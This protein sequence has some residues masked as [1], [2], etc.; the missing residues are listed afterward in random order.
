MSDPEIF[1]VGG[2]VQASGGLYLTR[3]VDSELLALCRARAYTYI[4]T[5]RQL[6]KSSLMVNT[7][8]RLSAEGVLPVLI[9]LT[10]CGLLAT[11]EEW[12]FG[13]VTLIAGALGESQDL[14]TWWT[15]LSALSVTQRLLRFFEDI[16]LARTEAPIV[17]FVDEIDCTLSLDFTDD[18]FVAIRL[19]HNARS[20][21]PALR[22]LTFV[23]IGVASPAE[24]Y[25]DPRRTPFNIGRRVELTDFTLSEVAPLAAGLPGSE[26]DR[27]QTLKWALAW[28]GGHP[29][30]TQRLCAAIAAEGQPPAS[31]DRMDALVATLFKGDLGRT[32]SNL[33]FVRD[34]LVRPSTIAPAVL[35]AYREVL[36]SRRPVPDDTQSMPKTRLKL[37]GIVTT[38]D[39]HLRVRNRLYAEVFDLDWIDRNWPR[40]WWS[41]IPYQVRVALILILIM[42][43]AL[44]ATA[45]YAVRQQRQAVAAAQL[46]DQ[47]TRLATG[48]LLTAES[49]ILSN[50]RQP[51]LSALLAIEVL[52]HGQPSDAGTSIVAENVL[53][54][55][56]EALKASI[57]YGH[58]G[59][60]WDVI[61]TPDGKWLVSSDTDGTALLW[62]VRRDA[63]QAPSI[64]LAGHDGRIWA[65]DISGD[66]RWLATA[67]AD[68]TA[69]LWDLEQPDPV[70]NPVILRAHDAPTLSLTFSPDGTLLATGGADG[71]LGLWRSQDS[72]WVRTLDTPWSLGAWVWDL[73]F[74]DDG[75]WLAA[76]DRTKT[77]RVWDLS[78][79]PTAAGLALH[80]HS[81]AI[82]DIEFI[83]GSSTLI[84]AGLDEL[85][86][87][88]DLTL[89]DPTGYP[90]ALGRHKDGIIAIAVNPD[91]RWL[92]T[93][94]LDQKVRLW[95][96]QSQTG[97]PAA[98]LRG[99]TELIFDEAFS[100]DGRY[101]ATS[102]SDHT[103]WLWNVAMEDPA[104]DAMTLLGHDDA[105][106][107][108][109]FSPQ[110]R[111]L[112]SAGWDG[113]VQL[114]DLSTPLSASSPFLLQ[115]HSSVVGRLAFSQHDQLL[116]TADANTGTLLWD[117]EID[118]F[119]PDPVAQLPVRAASASNRW[120]LVADEAGYA[121]I[122]G[123]EHVPRNAPLLLPPVTDW[124]DALALSD[125]G[126]WVVTAS[127]EPE[128]P[129]WESVILYPSVSQGRA[130][131]PPRLWDVSLLLADSALPAS[132]NTN[133]AREL[134]GLE[135]GVLLAHF[136]PDGHWLLTE[137]PDFVGALWPLPTSPDR[138]APRLLP[139][140]S[141]R[142]RA[143]FSADGRWLATA[144]ED[145]TVR[146]WD[147][148][149]TDLESTVRI[150]KNP[151]RTWD[152]A[153]SPDNRW[154]VTG[155]SDFAARLR[156]MS[157]L[158]TLEKPIVLRGHG[159]AVFSVAFS[160]DGRWLVTGSLDQTIRVWDLAT[161]GPAA[162]TPRVLV[163]HDDWV[164]ALAFSH[165]SRRLLSGA[166]DGTTLLWNLDIGQL[167]DVA[168]VAIGR[169][170]TPA[171]WTRF[172]GDDPYQPACQ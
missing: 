46:A 13:I 1:T 36:R 18:F 121:A 35:S 75:R 93:G 119:S 166:R 28:T 101:L 98:T 149:Q 117:K 55:S 96:L 51:R 141:G 138:A 132:A 115:G 160:P 102:S 3:P 171:E 78:G 128:P 61:F 155:D 120:L 48:R 56:L 20:Y 57:L 139:G 15:S 167:I 92:A 163:G 113:T 130:W 172:F 106:R 67:G 123:L 73:A 111:W 107:G 29:Y 159:G 8:E 86:L 25:H 26:A 89:A 168:C 142:W 126:R 157:E 80:G 19:L 114:W 90:M 12:Y 165:D 21:V 94:G 59:Q 76:S 2:A 127:R 6:G 134:P 54:Q 84:T 87:G 131:Q 71:R 60:V 103:V 145:Q 24:L 150:L 49:Q 30:L 53:R 151:G 31:S 16:V 37:S 104:E 143:A 70:A 116:L 81:D 144:G 40:D 43:V 10:E 34:M 22:R 68:G 95:D 42:A 100:P 39:D 108:I 64:R 63:P 154:L 91:G 23:L 65:L 152:L 38:R 147:L 74:S 58:A 110:G 129:L 97:S 11:A 33:Q 50:N 77:A 109:A 158:S 41:Q 124:R 17:I 88:W 146:L 170:L 99:H 47:Q 164:S 112:A 44:S 133:A 62:D 32:D 9:D 27:D 82:R 79:P 135:S 83:P 5:P 66:G 140:H 122:R 153:F 7:A 118:R 137:Q 45:L 156:D 72:T 161:P 125:D 162:T 52:R 105:V 85:V 4:L 136:S 69:R 148:L 14:H 169:S